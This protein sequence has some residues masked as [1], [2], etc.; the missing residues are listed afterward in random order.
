[1]PAVVGAPEK[2]GGEEKSV[3]AEAKRAIGGIAGPSP[4]KRSKRGKDGLNMQIYENYRKMLPPSSTWDRRARY[5]SI[6]KASSGQG[7]DD[8]FLVSALNHHVSII[9]VRVP[10]QVMSA[11]EGNE[12]GDWGR[13]VMWRSKWYD[14][15]I[16]KER[17]DAMQVIWGMMAFLMRKIEEPDTAKKVADDAKSEKMDLS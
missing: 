15:F 6:G 11:L 1:V 3:T 9:R 16:A 12:T 8:V 13:M 7:Y 17:V 4:S 5:S 14:L 10:D 2:I